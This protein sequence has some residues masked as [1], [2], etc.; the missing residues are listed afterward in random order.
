MQRKQDNTTDYYNPTPL[1]FV[2]NSLQKIAGATTSILTTIQQQQTS[3]ERKKDEEQKFGEEAEELKLSGVEASS[4]TGTVT[5][6]LSSIL[7]GASLTMRMNF[8]GL[9]SNCTLNLPLAVSRQ[10]AAQ[11]AV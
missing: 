10:Q 9:E 3:E 8:A 2:L 7:S 11:Q 6:V 5:N 1:E 4:M